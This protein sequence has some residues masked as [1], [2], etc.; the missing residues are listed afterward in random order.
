MQVTER[1]QTVAE[2]DYLASRFATVVSYAMAAESRNGVVDEPPPEYDSDIDAEGEEDD[3]LVM[4]L[5]NGVNG[6]HRNDDESDADAEGEEVDEEYEDPKE[7]D[8]GTVAIISRRSGA[9]EHES[10]EEEDAVIQ[11]SEDDAN[12]DSDNDTDPSAESGPEKEWD[13]ESDAGAG[14]ETTAIDPNRCV[15]CGQDEEHDPGEEFEEYLA[16]AVCG[17]NAHRQ[18]AREAAQLQPEDDPQAWR[19][20]TCVENGL[21]P[22]VKHEVPTTLRRR[23]SAPKITRDLLPAHRG[24]IKPDSHS[25][26]NTLILDDDPMDGSRSLRK[27]KA[28]VADE[29]AR[30][31]TNERKR[32]RRSG[33]DEASN[34]EGRATSSTSPVLARA[35]EPSTANVD[36]VKDEETDEGASPRLR[37][38]RRV[39]NYQRPLVTLVEAPG[40]VSFNL[41]PVRMQTILSARPRKSRKRDRARKI[42]AP[43]Q[44]VAEEEPAHY[45]AIQTTFSLFSE[46]F[47]EGKGKPYGGILDETE[48]DTAKTF[49]V[50]DD[51]LKFE[52]TR[53]EAEKLWQE[54]IARKSAASDLGRGTPKASGPPSKIKCVNF[55]GY[56]IDTWHAAPYPEEYSRNR[57]LYICEFCLK[58]MNSDYVA[59][60]HKLKCP[61]KRPPG[62]EIYRDDK[63]SFFEVD[64]RKNPVYCQNLCLLAKLFLGSKTLYYDVEPFLFYVMTENN[65]YG[66]HFVGYFSKEKRP[67]S[68]N[69]VS[70]I[71]TLPIH[72]RK[73]FGHMLIEFSY[74]LTRVEQ[75]TG[76]PEKPLSDMGLVTYRGY[77]RLVLAKQLLDQKGPI[78]I[79]TLS[80]RTGMT[81]DDIVSGLEGL[82]ALVRD[83]AT[84]TYALRLDFD[85]Y[86]E[87]IAK[88]ESKKHPT[89]NPEALMW[90]PYVMGRTNLSNY[91]DAPALHTVAQRDDDNALE[92]DEPEEGVQMEQAKLAN[93]DSQDDDMLLA[94]QV[95]LEIQSRSPGWTNPSTPRVN[96]AFTDGRSAAQ[97]I[98]STEDIPATRFEVFPPLR[99]HPASSVKRRNARLFGSRRRT[100]TPLQRANSYRSSH[101]VNGD[102]PAAGL[103]ARRAR[104]KLMEVVNGDDTVAQV[105]DMQV[106][107]AAAGN[108]DPEDDEIGIHEGS[109]AKTADHTEQDDEDEGFQPGLLEAENDE[110]E[111][112]DEEEEAEDEEAED[113]DAA[114]DDF[115]ADADGDDPDADGEADEDED[116]VEMDDAE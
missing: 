53:Q 67:S 13:G 77:W 37:K 56:E 39:R 99:R 108:E 35:A 14:A 25:V 116:D 87:F 8:S 75:K 5:T 52:K 45:P 23:S 33:E 24:A 49:P 111:E 91:E 60:R 105:E 88:Y 6:H 34:A 42:T 68:L 47:E 104:S 12:S 90:V 9:Q 64:G 7:A 31:R 19:C 20:N 32:Q 51:R 95:E 21:E 63:Y 28:S 102:T 85:Y 112:D 73:G 92:D 84:K 107:G 48:A 101:G 109:R 15:F 41:D 100:A 103:T 78:S 62:D 58:Y 43:S 26:F 94:S 86:R 17:D 54:K 55:G 38:N 18:C 115:D 113:D 22:D 76:S 96:G 61:A 89:I 71:L 74:L 27:R 110:E 106:N 65:D 30:P 10:D 83:A 70:C 29:V 80:E 93:G 97:S 69:N 46:G 1:L 66:Y 50:L 114:D 81:A 36:G 40:V 11:S 79:A 16:C 82:R 98:I 72:Q 44:I 57:V 2:L 3:D 59:W 4:P